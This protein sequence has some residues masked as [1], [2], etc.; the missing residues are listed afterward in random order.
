MIDEVVIS[1]KVLV[2]HGSRMG[3]TE[4][5]AYAVASKLSTMGYAVTI[6]SANDARD[7]ER[8]DAVVVGSSL[9][10]GRW[11]SGCVKLL[12]H[13]THAK[14]SGPVW[15]FQSGPLGDQADDPQPVPK[16]V[17]TLAAELD[18][19][20]VVTFG[21]RLEKNPPGVIAKAMAKE[22]AGDWRNWRHIDVWSAEIGEALAPHRA[23]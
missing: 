5:I 12:K 6:A 11:K 4:E 9:Y 22:Q 16:K 1:M 19:R 21:G 8:F 3:G 17:R 14:Y 7:A 18:V 2:A 20:G 15:L 13:L 23:A 10:A